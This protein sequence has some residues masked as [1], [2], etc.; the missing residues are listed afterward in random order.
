MP[1]ACPAPPGFAAAPASGSPTRPEV[2]TFATVRSRNISIFHS[3]RSFVVCE[4][5][6]V[7]PHKVILV[8]ADV[9]QQ[10]RRSIFLRNDQVGR[11]VAVEIGG[12]QP[13]R[14]CQPNA[15]Q[16][17]RVGSRL[18]SCRRR[19]C[20]RRAPAG[21]SFVSTI[22]AKSIQP[23]LSMSTGVRPHPRIGSVEWKFDPLKT[24]ADVVRPLHISP[25]REPGSACVRHG[26]IHPAVFVVIEHSDANRRRK[27]SVLIKRLR[28]IFSF[29]RIHIKQGRRRV[30]CDRQIHG[31][32]VVEIRENCRRGLAAS[33]QSSL[34]LVCSVNVPLPLLRH[35]TFDAS[36][37][38]ER[39]TGQE[40][41]QIAIVV[42][43]NK[44]DACGPIARHN[45]RFGRH[46]LELPVTQVAK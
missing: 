31:A 18:R 22:A 32:I 36:P 43:I 19:D 37:G 20:E 11:S 4:P 13:A 2:P 15:V 42:V 23:S 10:H 38:F 25:Q 8:R 1:G 28:G 6:Q 33:A 16:T 41:V 7:E 27:R 14:S 24:P 9:A 26:N 34:A 45:A 29:A 44:R 46:I 40:K 30:P 12:N 39:C 5:G 17:K 21:P 35:S 3:D